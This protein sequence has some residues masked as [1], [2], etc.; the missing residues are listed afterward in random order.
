MPITFHII[1]GISI[2]VCKLRLSCVNLV[3]NG[4]GVFRDVITVANPGYVVGLQSMV[5]LTL[6]T[7]TLITMLG[8][9]TVLATI[10]C[11]HF[12]LLLCNHTSTTVMDS[13]LISSRRTTCMP[14]YYNFAW[15][16]WADS[17]YSLSQRLVVENRGL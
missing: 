8:L 9:R 15:L 14:R 11:E 5:P 13:Q 3:S 10:C 2:N 7:H 4:H 16:W 12:T 6:L 1:I 17:R